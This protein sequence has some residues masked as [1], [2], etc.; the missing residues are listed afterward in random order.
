MHTGQV[1]AT[2]A[3]LPGKGVKEFD[4]N[5]YTFPGSRAEGAEPSPG[6]GIVL[7]EGMFLY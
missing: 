3:L 4:K 7:S 5:F 2:S 6:G 1:T